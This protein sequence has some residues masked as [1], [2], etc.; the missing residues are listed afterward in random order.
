MCCHEYLYEKK[1]KKLKLKQIAKIVK[2]H[3]LEKNIFILSLLINDN[4][5]RVKFILRRSSDNKN[6]FYYMLYNIFFHIQ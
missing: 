1:E 4:N 5:E 3:F 2:K 6:T